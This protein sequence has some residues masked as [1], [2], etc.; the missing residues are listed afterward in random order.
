MEACHRDASILFD[1]GSTY[2]CVSSYFAPNLDISRDS[3]NA[4]VN[5]S[6]LVGNSV[7][8]DHIYRSCLVN[9]AGYEIRVNLLL[10]NIID[11]YMNLGMD[12]LSPYHA[13]LD[14]HSKTMTLAMLGLPRLEWRGTLDYIPSNV[15]SFLKA[16]RMVE[17][18]C[19][20]YLAFVRDVSADT[21]SVESATVVRDF[22]DVFPIDLPSMSPD[23]D[24]DFD[25]DL[26]LGTPP[27][28]IPPYRMAP[29][30]LLELKKQLQE[31]LDK[32]FIR[33]SVSPWGA[34][35]LFVKNKYDSMRIC[36]DYRHLD[37]VTVKNKYPL[38]C[39]DDLFD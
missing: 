30:E 36:I 20:A 34:L 21:H 18:G 22:Q 39:I 38:M 31:L 2:S 10:L 13:I 35:V 9:I 14:C 12:W 23:R 25:I 26:L 6:M 17:K 24:I 1:H 32:G 28:S 4:H 37:K 33:Q 15:V 5:V 16:H 27:I 11:F 3:L 8:V 29:L 7:I 19:K